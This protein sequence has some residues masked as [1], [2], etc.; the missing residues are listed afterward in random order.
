MTGSRKPSTRWRR[1]KDD[2]PS[3]II[4]AAL[5]CFAERG[6]AATR[7]EDVAR[8]AGVTKGTLYLYFP[9]KEELFKAV[10]RRTIVAGIA[11]GESLVE[12][13]PDPTPV[14]LRRLIEHWLAL[15]AAPASAIPKL[16][17]SEA[18]NFPDLARFY[19]EE[20]VL[21]GTRLIRT[22]LQTGVERG[23]FRPMAVEHAAICVVAP[24]IFN[25]LWRHSFERYAGHP[26][27]GAAIARVHLDM[28]LHGLCDGTRAATP[29]RRRRDIKGQSDEH[30]RIGES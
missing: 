13:S 23:E 12:Q 11:Q 16:V 18:G 30:R 3:E 9:N 25:M 28:L 19:L 2:R 29:S 24:M 27:D 17:L 22:L 8:N 26:L 1:R 10:V 15:Q 7:L 4:A 6:F 21:R 5:A 20:V 14:L